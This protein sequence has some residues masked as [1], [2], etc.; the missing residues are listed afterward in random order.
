[1]GD[2][3]ATDSAGRRVVAHLD[4]EGLEAVS[5]EADAFVA[6]VTLDARDVERIE[7]H[8]QS[9]LEAVREEDESARWRD[10]GYYLVFPVAL[11]GLLWFR[12]GWTVQWM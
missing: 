12:K 2:T 7:R 6:T 10:F 8:V 3:F 1:M 11:L 4:R 5:R 9:H